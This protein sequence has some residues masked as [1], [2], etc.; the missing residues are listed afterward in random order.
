MTPPSK[1]G[2]YLFIDKD[3]MFCHERRTKKKTES[4]T[5]D[6]DLFIGFGFLLSICLLN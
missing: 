1:T 2:E 5:G 3:E 6:S 4:P